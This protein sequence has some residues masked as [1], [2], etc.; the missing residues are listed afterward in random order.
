V[1]IGILGGGQ[2]GYMLALAGYPL[3]LRFRFLDPSPEAPVGRIAQRVTAD[4]DDEAALEALALGMDLRFEGHRTFLAGADVSL[5]GWVPVEEKEDLLRRAWLLLHP[6]EVEG[7]GLVVMEAAIWETPTIGFDVRGVRDSVADGHS[8][9]LVGSADE[10][11]EAWLKLAADDCARQT[12]GR[13]A[14][15]RA[16]EYS[17]SRTVD[18]FLD[19]VR[20]A[21]DGGRAVGAPVGSANRRE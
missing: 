1:T 21:V 15:R 5:P 7:W 13:N 11:A 12:L 19:V 16:G 20:E 14:R 9:L 10:M 3:G 8:G 2:L 18:G 6:S 17:W 4:F